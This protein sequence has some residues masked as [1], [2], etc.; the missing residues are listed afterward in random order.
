MKNLTA[1]APITTPTITPTI[2]PTQDPSK[3]NIEKPSVDP[4][5]KA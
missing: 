4:A 1:N 3:I 2:T 5:P